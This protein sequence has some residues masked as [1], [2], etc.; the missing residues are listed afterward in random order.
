MP[1]LS[2]LADTR[3]SHRWL[4]LPLAD[5]TIHAGNF[6]RLG[7]IDEAL[8]FM[9]WLAARPGAKVVVAGTLDVAARE[10]REELDA[11]CRRRGIVLL[12]SER[13]SVAGLRVWGGGSPPRVL[14]AGID[15]LVTHEAPFGIGD[16]KPFGRS[17]GSHAVLD[18]AFRTR[19]RVH[20]F[21]GSTYEG[22]RH[23][24]TGVAT[25]F[26]NAAISPLTSLLRRP[27]TH[28]VAGAVATTAPTAG[29]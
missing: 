29:V 3:S 8:D 20:V 7:T 2:V 21:C 25:V 9:D 17:F 4:R 24:R 15:V 19:P 14:E 13:A 18:A 23:D 11:E 6:T 10:R 16:R 12:S 26:L 1:I 5:L 27:L 22:G 28:L